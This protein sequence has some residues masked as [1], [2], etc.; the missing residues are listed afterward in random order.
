MKLLTLISSVKELE[1]I[2]LYAL[3]MLKSL[4]AKTKVALIIEWVV[5]LDIIDSADNTEVIILLLRVSESV[6]IVIDNLATTKY[7]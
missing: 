6:T 1:L 7:Y 3:I 4:I 2:S 5:N